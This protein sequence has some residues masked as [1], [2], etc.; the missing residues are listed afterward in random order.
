MQLDKNK[1]IALAIGGAFLLIIL[2]AVFIFS[3]GNG[4]IVG[5]GPVTLRWW[6]PFT[7]NEQLYLLKTEYETR[8]PNVT[9]EITSKPCTDSVCSNYQ[10][11]LLNAFALGK[12]PDIFSIH[13]SW[14]PKYLDKVAS[15]TNFTFTEYKDTFVDTAVADFTRNEKIY[16]VALSVDS[17]ALYYN[18]DILFS[19]NLPLPPKTWEELATYSRLVTRTDTRTGYVSQSGVSFGTTQNVYR[20]Q[21]ILYLFMLQSGVRPWSEDG[22]QPTFAN[23]VMRDGQFTEAGETALAFYTSFANSK[24][25]NYTWNNRSDQSI[26]AFVNGRAA[27]LYGYSFVRDQILQKNP[28]LNFDI[29]PVPQPRSGN[30]V[31]NFANYWGEVVNA[32][33]QSKAVAWDFLKFITT[34]PQLSQYYAQVKVPA[35]RKDLVT[36]QLQDPVLGVFASANLTAKSFLRPDEA[37]M[38]QIF[39]QMVDDVIL[40]GKTVNDALQNAQIQASSLTQI[41][42]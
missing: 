10:D 17:L 6:K 18:K 4:P 22:L 9:I 30:L 36:A 40:R 11:E 34:K 1:K 24:T 41:R 3:K 15:S 35:S 33:S 31:I 21:D 28:T 7:D 27:F 32:R 20:P 19:Q 8:H 29:A 5:Q 37:K 42:F 23:P 16:G 38:E 12:G 2:V 13:N 39:R 14:L 26:D 25:Q